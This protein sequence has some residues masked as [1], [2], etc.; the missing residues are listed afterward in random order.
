MLEILSQDLKPILPC[1]I[2]EVSMRKNIR[3]TG[4]DFKL[5]H[6]KINLSINLCN[7]LVKF[8]TLI[9]LRIKVTFNYKYLYAIDNL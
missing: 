7:I 1:K 6:L 9:R 4:S 8:L 5:V 2:Q 3:S